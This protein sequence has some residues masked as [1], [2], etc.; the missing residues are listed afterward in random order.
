MPASNGHPLA[1]G[2]SATEI[3][4]SL[5]IHADCLDW[6]RRAAENSIHAVVTDPPYGVKEYEADQ[7][8]KLAQGRGGVWRIP[9][10]FDGHARAPLPRF[11]ALD[12]SERQG[13][14]AFFQQWSH[15]ALRALRPG[16]QD[17]P[18]ATRRRSA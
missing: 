4:K 5:I 13:M 3:G 14:R 2:F 6:L 10:S 11:T 1:C 15:L 8:A 7:L 17:G 16:D 9:P 12:E 18:N